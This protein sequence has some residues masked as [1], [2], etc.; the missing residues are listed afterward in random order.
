MCAP[1]PAPV[2]PAQLHSGSTQQ[3]TNAPPAWPTAINAQPQ[4]HA[5]HA[6]M[7]SS[8]TAP[9]KPVQL[10]WQTAICVPLPINVTHV[11]LISSSTEQHVPLV[12]LDVKTAPMPLHVQCVRRSLNLLK[13]DP[14]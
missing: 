10:V 11:P 14:V 5:T 6:L 1:T 9:L 12:E 3:I 7:D 13:M 2:P 8:M 4:T